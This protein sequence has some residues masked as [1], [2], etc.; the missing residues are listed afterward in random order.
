MIESLLLN[1]QSRD[2]LSKAEQDILRD[3]IL[4]NRKVAAG[5]DLVTEGSRPDFSTLILDGFAA[6]YKVTAEGSRQ[7]TAL[8]V[9]GDFVD[10]CERRPDDDGEQDPTDPVQQ[11]SGT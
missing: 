10:L 4:R 5:E 11:F 1:L 3:T 6:R 9:A 2:V 8:H 7:I